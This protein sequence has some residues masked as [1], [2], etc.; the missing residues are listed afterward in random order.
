MRILQLISKETMPQK[1]TFQSPYLS[2]QSLN[3]V[4]LPDFALVTGVNGSGK[5]HLLMAISSE[6]IKSDAVSQT[7]EVSIFTWDTLVPKDQNEAKPGDLSEIGTLLNQQLG[8]FAIS[9]KN[10]RLEI[11]NIDGGEQSV[12]L[13]EFF[14]IAKKDNGENKENIVSKIKEIMASNIPGGRTSERYERA[15]LYINSLDPGA[16]L[17]HARALLGENSTA[18]HNAM[19]ALDMVTPKGFEQELNRVFQRYRDLENGNTIA[20]ARDLPD[21]IIEIEEPAP[22][23]FLNELFEKGNIAFRVSPPDYV[24][25][26]SSVRVTLKK[27]GTDAEIGFNNLSSGE[28]IF[29]SFAIALYN[30]EGAKTKA[31]FPK[32]LLLDEIDATLHPSMVKY[33]LRVIK[34]TLVTKLGIKVILTTHSPTTVALVDDA[35]VY[36]MDNQAGQLKRVGRSRALSLLT[37]AIPTLA[38]DYDARV[39]V[40]TEDESDAKLWNELYTG[41]RGHLS[42]EKSLSFMGS[43][44]KTEKGNT[45]GGGCARVR[46]ITKSMTNSGMSRVVGLVDWDAKNTSIQGDCVHVLCEGERYAIENLLLDPVLCIFLMCKLHSDK[47]V[48]DGF[49]KESEGFRSLDRWSE[50]EWQ[51]KVS[52]F[53]AKVLPEDNLSSVVKIRYSNGS[54]LNIPKAYLRHQGHPLE[55]KVVAAYPCFKAHSGSGK[56]LIEIARLITVKDVG[57]WYPESI[58]KTMEDLVSLVTPDNVTNMA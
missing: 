46:A 37:E 28:R 39:L 20:K 18:R 7:S 23:D 55:K 27:N 57:G 53:C 10:E 45:T 49:M 54:T 58:T 1:L 19:L 52:I 47:A 40:V 33:V 26:N 21:R 48:R 5:S 14:E 35:E 13:A 16:I 17:K 36:E 12:T 8:K 43:G 56:L 11:A 44:V 50:A 15:L 6:S 41:L 38:I 51:S 3:S 22:W 24:A 29:I 42:S 34:E 25:V 9:N 4:E 2:I 32:L 31:V 30:T